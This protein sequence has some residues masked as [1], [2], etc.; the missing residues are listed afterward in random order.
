MNTKYK[1]GDYVKVHL[2]YKSGY[3]GLHYGLN[4]QILRIDKMNTKTYSFPIYCVGGAWF[5]EED[6][7]PVTFVPDI[8]PV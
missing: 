3:H 4:G 8:I 7:K 1:V 5:P 6:L 2:E